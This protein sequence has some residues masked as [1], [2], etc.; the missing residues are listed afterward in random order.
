MAA[1]VAIYAVFFDP[2][3]IGAQI[4]SLQGLLPQGALEVVSNELRRIASQNHGAQGFAMVAGLL[5]AIWSA[6]SAIKA[7]FD[8]LNQV[9]GEKEERGFFAIT[10]LTSA[11]SVFSFSQLISPHRVAH[12]EC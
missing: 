4:A 9:Y 6:N 3:V 5:I 11:R 7:L 12:I 10:V 2:D 1:L 8:S